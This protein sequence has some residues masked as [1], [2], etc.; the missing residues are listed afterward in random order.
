MKVFLLGTSGA[1]GMCVLNQLLSR[2]YQASVYLTNIREDALLINSQL[3]HL[4]KTQ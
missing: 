1:T 2:S 3:Q 4:S